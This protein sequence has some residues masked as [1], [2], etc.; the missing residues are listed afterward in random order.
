ILRNYLSN[1]MRYTEKGAVILR[2]REGGGGVRI[3]AQDTGI[4]IPPDKHQ[5]IFREFHQLSNPERDRTKGLGLGLAIVERL[6]RLLAHPVVV[7]SEPGRG[8]V[9]SIVVPL[10][11]PLEVDRGLHEASDVGVADVSG[12]FVLVIDDEPSVREG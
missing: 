10:G 2:A 5:E 6:S 1:A 12:M 4:G 8:S 7:D 9:F 3:E 11:D